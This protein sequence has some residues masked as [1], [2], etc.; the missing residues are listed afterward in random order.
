[1]HAWE[2]DPRRAGSTLWWRKIME[3]RVSWR[4]KVFKFKT[5]KTL[6]EAELKKNNIEQCNMSHC[7]WINRRFPCGWILILDEFL[8]GNRLIVNFFSNHK[9]NTKMLLFQTGIDNEEFRT[10]LK[11]IFFL[12]NVR[13]VYSWVKYRRTPFVKMKT[14]LL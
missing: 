11:I 2:I 1:M 12:W 9:F 13:I 4:M 3:Q 8:V 10:A 5:I 7:L 14:A 6:W